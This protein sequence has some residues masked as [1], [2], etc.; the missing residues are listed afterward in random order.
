MTRRLRLEDPEFGRLFTAIQWSWFR[1]ETLQHYD[2]SYEREPYDAFHAGRTMPYDPGDDE[3]KAMVRD[4]VAAG[5]TLQRVHV[6]TEPLTPYIEYELTWGYKAGLAGGEDIRVIVC[7]EATW[8][9]GV[10][11][12]H[13]FWLLDDDLWIMKYDEQGQLD[14]AEQTTDPEAIA[15]H[16]RWRDAALAHSTPVADYLS[17][18]PH[19]RM[20]AAS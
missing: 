7:P 16:R 13:D 9:S 1:L 2:V 4:H 18:I 8:P 10:P 20:R 17:T 5:K 11:S 6:I 19:L 14:H 15:A 12:E 3:W